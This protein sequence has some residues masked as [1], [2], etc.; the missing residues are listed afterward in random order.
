MKGPIFTLLAGLV[1]IGMALGVAMCW[2][3]MR[4]LR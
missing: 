1:V 2:L 3:V 4:V